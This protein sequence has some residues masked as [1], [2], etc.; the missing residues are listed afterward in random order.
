MLS[1]AAAHLAPA[2]QITYSAMKA[3]VEAASRV[4]AKELGRRSITVN[5]VRPGATDTRRL[6]DST[7]SG[8]VEAMAAAPA[9]GASG[10]LPTLPVSSP[11]SP[12]T[13]HSGSQEL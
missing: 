11:G 8:A 4:A 7:S 13:M 3:G 12:P 1:S 9:S 5:V 10:P 2:R 6:H